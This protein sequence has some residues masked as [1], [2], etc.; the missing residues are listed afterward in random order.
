[1]NAPAFVSAWWSHHNSKECCWQSMI[2][3]YDFSA[4]PV[5]TLRLLDRRIRSK[6]VLRNLKNIWHFFRIHLMK[7]FFCSKAPIVCSSLEELKVFIPDYIAAIGTVACRSQ[8]GVIQKAGSR[9]VTSDGSCSQLK[10]DVHH[11]VPHVS[12][13]PRAFLGLNVADVRCQV[14]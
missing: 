9:L 2:Y 6:N 13:S 3:D 11:K 5:V 7:L 12:W 14:A 10:P 4:S 8:K 1:M